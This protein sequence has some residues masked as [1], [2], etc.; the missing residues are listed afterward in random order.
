MSDPH[1]ILI[2]DEV[3]PVLL[4]MLINH[5]VNYQPDIT[6]DQLEIALQEATNFN[7][8][9]QALYQR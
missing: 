2:I 6:T 9:Y 4:D 7:R 1:H 3:H 8:A 5:S